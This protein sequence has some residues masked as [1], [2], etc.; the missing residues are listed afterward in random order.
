MYLEF[1]D[2][3]NLDLNFTLILRDMQSSPNDKRLQPIKR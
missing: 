2:V 1:K 3:L